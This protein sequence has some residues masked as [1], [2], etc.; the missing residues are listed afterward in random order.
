MKSPIVDFVV[1][2]KLTQVS[3]ILELGS[4]ILAGYL[5][6]NN[7]VLAIVVLGFAF[8]MAVIAGEAMMQR[9]NGSS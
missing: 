2:K 6:N 9:E 3:Q 7:P 5:L 1:K 8:I 4:F